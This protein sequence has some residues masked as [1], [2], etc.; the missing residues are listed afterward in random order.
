MAYEATASVSY[1]QMGE[2]QS[3]M[4]KNTVLVS[5]KAK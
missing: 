1:D 3:P 5:M 2:S 4:G